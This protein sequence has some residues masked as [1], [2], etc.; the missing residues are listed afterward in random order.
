M[1]GRRALIMVRRYRSDNVEKPTNIRTK[2]AD[3]SN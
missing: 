1:D 2:S 3:N